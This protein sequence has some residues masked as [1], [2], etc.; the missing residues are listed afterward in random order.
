MSK[1]THTH[2]L[3]GGG[4]GLC[5]APLSTPLLR[6]CASLLVQRAASAL[7]ADLSVTP[8]RAL[9]MRRARAVHPYQYAEDIK[10][11]QTPI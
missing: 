10:A 5:S 11:F 1:Q 8:T 4:G 2:T 9:F 3:G 6:L 7:S